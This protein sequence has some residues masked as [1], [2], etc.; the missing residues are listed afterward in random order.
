M[1]ILSKFSFSQ[2]QQQ[3]KMNS[4]TKSKIIL[5]DTLKIQGE[6]IEIERDNIYR[7]YL[8]EGKKPETS[9]KIQII[10]GY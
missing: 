9:K 1:F 8:R 5:N 4:T 10:K 2:T 7:Q 3:Q 6:Q